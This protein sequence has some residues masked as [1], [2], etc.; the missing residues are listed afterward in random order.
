[1]NRATAF[2][3]PAGAFLL[4]SSTSEMTLRFVSRIC[5]S[6]ARENSA[7]VPEAIDAR[8]RL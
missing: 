7:V 6:A 1:L 8:L 3:V 4:T 2:S 5:D